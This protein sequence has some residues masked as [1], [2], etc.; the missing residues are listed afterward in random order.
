MAAK[1]LRGMPIVSLTTAP[2]FT[3]SPRPAV[4]LVQSLPGVMAV[5][6]VHGVPTVFPAESGDVAPEEN[7]LQTVYN[8][9]PAA[10]VKLS[11]REDTYV[12][13][14]SYVCAPAKSLVPPS[15]D[16]V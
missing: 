13:H 6:R 11:F 10:K 1:R 16:V 2:L 12:L 4:P 15:A 5:K 7:L 14:V 8:M 3:A 9:R